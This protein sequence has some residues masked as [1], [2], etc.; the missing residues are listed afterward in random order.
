MNFSAL[1]TEILRASEM[2]AHLYTLSTGI[3]LDHHIAPSLAPLKEH[4]FI[5]MNTLLDKAWFC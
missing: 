5:E 2:G 1:K 3:W 4:K